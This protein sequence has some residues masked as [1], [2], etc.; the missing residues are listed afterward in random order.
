MSSDIN[1]LAHDPVIASL[2]KQLPKPADIA[3][4]RDPFIE[5]VES[6]VSQ[7]LSVKVAAI[8]TERLYN[9]LPDRQMTPQNILN[10]DQEAVRACG[11]SYAKIRYIRSTAD[12]AL[13]GLVDFPNLRSKSDDEVVAELVQIVGVGQWTAE[14]LLIFC[15]GRPDV[16]SVGDLGIRTAISKL[17]AINREDRAAMVKLA[18]QWSPYRSLACRYLWASLNN[19]PIVEV[20]EKAD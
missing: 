4:D 12:A 8:I 16:F 3:A 5:L 14:M 15:L 9:L 7:Q 2:I 19:T 17:Y 11:I 13:S 10:L 6:I 1:H 20:K 18:E